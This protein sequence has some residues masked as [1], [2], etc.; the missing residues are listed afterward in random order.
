LGVVLIYFFGDSHTH[1][2]ENL[3]DYKHIPYSVH[4]AKLLNVDYEMHAECGLA[5]NASVD[6]LIHN[7][8]KI[9]KGDFVLF[10]FQTLLNCRYR[11]N[12]TDEKFNWK[13]IDK[14]S[15]LSLK[16]K[17][18]ILDFYSKFVNVITMEEVDRVYLIF[19]Y[20][21][22]K[23]IKCGALYWGNMDYYI[24]SEYNL[25]LDKE[26]YVQSYYEYNIKDIPKFISDETNIDDNHLS[27]PMNK[28]IAEKIYETNYKTN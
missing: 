16:D 17:N 6:K 10:Q 1:G 21:T 8:D 2:M 3:G 9:K 27:N 15:N 11:F 12:K 4:L 25:L 14:M 26:K 7:L 19:D 23:G 5:L 18:L 13:E 20:L 22:S 28:V 24:D